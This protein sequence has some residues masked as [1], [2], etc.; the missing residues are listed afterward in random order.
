MSGYA[1][2]TRPAEGTLHDLWAKA[3]VL[4]DASGDRHAFI[5]L[6]LVGIGRDISTAICDRLKS[7]HG[8]QRAQISLF[9]SHTH[10]GP[11]VGGNLGAMYFVD[12]T[13]RQKIDDYA[14]FLPRAVD[15]VVAAAIDD[16]QT[17][18]ITYGMGSAGFAVNRRN[19]READVPALRA[20]GELKGPV[21]HSVPVL[22]IRSAEGDLRGVMFGY[23][24]HATVLSFYQWSGD[25]PGFAQIEIEKA[26]PGVTAL[27]MAGCGAD[28]NPLPRRTVELAE[29]YG[30]Q[31]AAA[32]TDVLQQNMESLPQPLN[33]VYEEIPLALAEL[34]SKEQIQKNLQSSNR[35]EVGRAKLLLSQIEKNGKLSST[36]PYPVQ[37]VGFG[38][39]VRLVVLGGEVV[40]D[41]SNRLRREFPN[42]D[43]WVAGY[44]NDVMAYIPSLRVLRE[45]GYEGASSMVYYGLP[46]VWSEQVEEHIVST[47][48]KLAERL[49]SAA[50]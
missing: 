21:D 41:Y 22:A 9:T 10:T 42:Y 35:Y 49:G 14:R 31:T 27:F 50:K 25:W 34:P 1:S 16:L 15:D 7:E 40:V 33:A 2:R 5:S 47:V 6:D 12:Q 13:Q 26:Y 20:Q 18:Q 32:V 17:S 30:R 11:V 39:Q 28:Q 24:C 4:Q 23:A 8:L 19:N 43:L 36:Y 44:A 29:N 38:D 3:I 45:G 46:T 37:I 48:H